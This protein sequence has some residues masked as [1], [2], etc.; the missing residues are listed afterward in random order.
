MKKVIG[1]LVALAIV[2]IIA[3]TYF[4]KDTN[5]NILVNGESYNHKELIELLN[6][7]ISLKKIEDNDLN[8]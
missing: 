4:K 3:S 7:T 5:F 6:N 8:F 1:V 2:I